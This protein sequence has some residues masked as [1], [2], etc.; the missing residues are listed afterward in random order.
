MKMTG[1]ICLDIV[2]HSDASSAYGWYAYITELDL[3]SICSLQT[4]I[5]R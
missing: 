3:S 2:I 4:D 5:I 1:D